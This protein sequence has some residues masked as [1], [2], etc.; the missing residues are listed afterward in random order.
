MGKQELGMVAKA[1]E[2]IKEQ[3]KKDTHSSM[4]AFDL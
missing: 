2:K 3:L 4:S 1:P